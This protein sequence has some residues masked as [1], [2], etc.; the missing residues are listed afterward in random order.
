MLLLKCIIN[1]NKNMPIKKSSKFRRN[2]AV[3]KRPAQTRKSKFILPWP[4][5]V[6]LVIAIG[7]LLVGWT[8]QAIAD[9]VH[10]TAKVS[11]PLPSGPAVITSPGDSSRFTSVP[12]TVSGTCPTD[13]YIK[14]YRNNF[15]SGTA[16]C[17]TD[18][19][20]TLDIDLF[21]GQ[22][23]LEP[24]I[25][26]LT[27]DE[28]PSSV[29]ITVYYDVPE[30]PTGGNSGNGNSTPQPS[31]GISAPSAN[32]QAGPFTIKTDFAYRGF[33]VGQSIEWNF[34]ANGGVPPYAINIDWGDGTNSLVS[35]K[36]SGK[37]TVNHR[38]KKV[39]DGTKGSY[40]VKI[41]GID[42][43]GRQTFLQL[44]LIIVPSGVPGFVSNTLPAGPK[45]SSSWLKLIW[46]GY[47]IVI[48][49]SVSFWL[50]EREEL[51]E[52]RNRRPLRRR[53]T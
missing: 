44:F 4:F 9:D 25:F 41:S 36:E 50:G 22:N 42:S 39:G 6:F 16:M 3:K 46:P 17:T 11:A 1:K 52:L 30:Q 27:D 2:A 37:V 45:I 32:I 10:V 29:P 12:I 38:Y 51:I 40:K 31:A 8:F 13:T 28:G 23:K 20:F 47:L 33:K 15:F 24:K 5:L 48:L 43:Q 34:E 19:N 14:I 7:V 35:Q 26:N 21:P 53:H 18:G 49:M